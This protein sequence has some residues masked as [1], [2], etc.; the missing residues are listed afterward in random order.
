MRPVHEY[1]SPQRVAALGL[2]T[3]LVSAASLA[4]EI[5]LDVLA[6]RYVEF[7][8]PVP[9]PEAEL[10]LVQLHDRADAPVR[11]GFAKPTAQGYGPPL[12]GTTRRTA[13]G[14]PQIHK[15]ATPPDV[16]IERI[17]R[18]WLGIRKGYSVDTGFA[19]AIHCWRRGWKSFARTLLARSLSSKQERSWRRAGVA[20]D[21]EVTPD[22]ALF[23]LA[24]DYWRY[25][26]DEPRADW[27]DILRRLRQLATWRPGL[28]R[29]A[30]LSLVNSLEATLAPRNS[31]AGSVEALIDD[32]VNALPGAEHVGDWLPDPEYLRITDF[33]FAAVPVLIEHIDDPRLTRAVYYGFNDWPGWRPRVESVVKSMLLDFAGEDVLEGWVAPGR[34][35]KLDADAA[36]A[37]WAKIKKVDEAQYYVDHI[38]TRSYGKAKPN[39]LAIRMLRKKYPKRLEEAFNR[40]L[41]QLPNA[42]TEQMT[43]AIVAATLPNT[44]KSRMLDRLARDGDLDRT[45]YALG[46]L[47]RIGAPAFAP[48]LVEALDALPNLENGPDI[49]YRTISLGSYALLTDNARV[50]EALRRTMARVHRADQ[51]YLLDGLTNDRRLQEADQ[52]RRRILVVGFLV[53]MLDVP[54]VKYDAAKRLA[55][56]LSLR[57]DYRDNWSIREKDEFLERV[58]AAGEGWL[59][60]PDTGDRTKPGKDRPVF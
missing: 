49:K 38:V 45:V 30:H 57:E 16:P 29:Q 21:V 2:V 3:A 32:L 4:G 36:R 15:A 58:R 20:S 51:L 7:G 26:I 46:A 41:K 44:D 47:G 60:A 25:R 43:D 18:R 22:V 10:V 14:G 6:A 52:P 50:W 1:C 23:A 59:R 37:W 13:Y 40:L 53:D 54:Y 39:P 28:V 33:G 24:W 5:D 11:I 48:L 42:D 56:M 8:L 9:E 55:R 12:I 19:N 35:W 31:P 17:E 34:T 27:A